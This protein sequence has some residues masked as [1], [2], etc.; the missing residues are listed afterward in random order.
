[1]AMN[2]KTAAI[3]GLGQ[4]GGSLALALK[5]NSCF[6]SIGGF[7]TKASRLH[8]AKEF[9]DF[10]C[11]SEEEAM[12]SADIIILAAPVLENIR[13]L[14]IACQNKYDKL[15]TDVGSTKTQIMQKSHENPGIRFV[16]GHPFAGTEKPGEAGWD[17]TLFSG[18][19]YFWIPESS[20]SEEDI[21]CILDIIRAIG[22]VPQSVDAEEHDR[23]LA[24]TSHLPILISLSLAGLLEQDDSQMDF[25]GNGFL[26]TAR[27][28]GGSAEMGKD[29]LMSNKEAVLAE[30]VRFSKNLDKFVECL[31]N[32]DENQLLELMEKHRQIY[33]SIP[34]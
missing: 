5:N 17:A 26:S 23:M 33:I 27:L 2:K 34:K 13:L 14:K 16:G 30:M 19:P 21:Q 10:C 24:Y 11:D 15:Y 18:K 25:V 12:V 9:L 3:I 20:Q 29:I 4:I 31:R 32:S 7:D 28:A 6:K 22:A 1:M 8:K